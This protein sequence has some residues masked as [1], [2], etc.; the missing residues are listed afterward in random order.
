MDN[1]H[2][3]TEG[4]GKDQ[5]DMPA[6]LSE[7]AHAA[8]VGA[9]CCGAA[10]HDIYIRRAR[11][12]CA[13][14]TKGNRRTPIKSTNQQSWNSRSVLTHQMNRTNMQDRRCR[15]LHL[16]MNVNVCITLYMLIYIS[17]IHMYDDRY[18]TFSLHAYIYICMYVAGKPTTELAEY[19]TKNLTY[20]GT[21]TQ[22]EVYIH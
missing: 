8:A 15:H 13:H 19:K 1:K 9:W 3:R 4:R 5:Y 21:W 14:K 12:W 6:F 10:V 20:S 17:Y 2:D 18:S 16:Q 7:R 11:S 22:E